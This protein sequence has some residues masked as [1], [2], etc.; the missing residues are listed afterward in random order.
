[1]EQTFLR[2]SLWALGKRRGFGA[3]PEVPVFVGFPEDDET[4]PPAAVEEHIE[5]LGEGG[6]KT[7]VLRWSGG[8]LAALINPEHFRA[9]LEAFDAQA[10][11]CR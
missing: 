8:H 11:A 10:R 4:V 2:E 3:S 5:K 6:V 1:M 9:E 7:T